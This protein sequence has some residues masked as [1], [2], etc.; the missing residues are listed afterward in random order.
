MKGV[1]TFANARHAG[2]Q[3][4]SRWPQCWSVS[5]RMNEQLSEWLKVRE[6]IDAA[7]RAGAIMSRVATAI[8]AADP[9]NVLDLATGAGSNV[10]YLVERLP[11]RQRWLVVDRNPVLLSHLLQRTQEWAA[12]RGYETETAAETLSIRGNGREYDVTT[13]EGDLY[14]VGAE[15]ADGRHLVTASALLDLV[16]E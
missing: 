7:S 12:A 11:P 13:R 5:P 14:A 6:A 8:A 1:S 10:R 15:L 4:W 3:P 2:T 16:S 9:V